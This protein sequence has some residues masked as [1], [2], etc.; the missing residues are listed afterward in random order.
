[1][2]P[3]DNV[4]ACDENKASQLD[5]LERLLPEETR[6]AFNVAYGHAE[7]TKLW[8]AFQKSTGPGIVNHSS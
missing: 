7:G 2:A 1:L 5:T 8:L 4:R 6:D 3:K